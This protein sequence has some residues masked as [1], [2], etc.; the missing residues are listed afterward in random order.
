[1]T[2][3]ST[4]NRLLRLNVGFLLKQGAGYSREIVFEHDGP[5]QAE[6]VLLNK[7]HG[8]LRL[9]RTPQGV[10]VQG[11]LKTNSRQ[12]CIRCLTDL[13]YPF[14]VEISELFVPSDS[15]KSDPDALHIG[16]DDYIDLTPI[17]REEAILAVPIHV[18]CSA[19]CKGLCPICG[20][21][22]NETTC[23]CDT[24]RIDPRFESLR[25]LLDEFED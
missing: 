19:D 23:D 25:A 17:V 9:S 18:V 12:A 7:L 6:D 5:V 3:P 10:L 20:E 24:D 21:N 11:V 13:D 8:T 16:E 1:M 2:T 4:D 14:E 15:E 22:R